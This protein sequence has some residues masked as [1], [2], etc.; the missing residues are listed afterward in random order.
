MRRAGAFWLAAAV[1]VSLGVASPQAGAERI[2][3]VGDIHGSLDGLTTILK[4]VGLIDGDRRWSG[5]STVF[6]QTGDYTDRG[7]DVLQVMDLLMDLQEQAD[8]AGGE[9]IVLLGNHETMNLLRVTRDVNPNIYASL[10]TPESEDRRDQGL[11]D[12][13]ESLD[14]RIADREDLPPVTDADRVTW[15]ASHPP[16]YIEYLEAM[17][18]DGR[19]GKWLRKRPVTARVGKIAFIHAGANPQ[20]AEWKSTISTQSI[21]LSC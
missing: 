6:V 10:V 4:K 12:Y 16:G 11:K 2:V 3:A 7:E 14:E 9:V 20:L 18:P 21:A 1:V 13:L 5:G 19:Y 17:G 15:L 8:K